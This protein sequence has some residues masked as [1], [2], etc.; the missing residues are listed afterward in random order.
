MNKWITFFFV[1]I[2]TI[3]LLLLVNQCEKALPL[4]KEENSYYNQR[5]NDI[6]RKLELKIDSIQSKIL[7]KN[8][9]NYYL[10]KSNEEHLEQIKKI[11][12]ES[13]VDSTVNDSTIIRN[14]NNLKL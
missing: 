7:I 12:K 14:W 10:L 1:V 4:S 2:A 8:N 9:N 13:C 11:S 6:E 5:Q 3:L